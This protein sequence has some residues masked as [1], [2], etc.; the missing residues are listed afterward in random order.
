M[1]STAGP[2]HLAQSIDFHERQTY[3]EEETS[4]NDWG[5]TLI[6]IGVIFLLF[7]LLIAVF[8][9]REVR[10]GTFFFVK[11]ILIQTVVG[12]LFISAGM[13]QKRKAHTKDDA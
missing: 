10:D 4:K 8:I 13:A 2:N 7:D 1:A 9:T 12:S 3:L 6:T 5:A 11:W